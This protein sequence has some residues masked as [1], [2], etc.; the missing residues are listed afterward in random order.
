MSSDDE[1]FMRLALNLGR[2]GLGNTW[3]NPAVGAV[4]VNRLKDSRFPNTLREVIYQPGQ[5]AVHAMAARG[6][7]SPESVRAAEAALRGE[8]PT[9]GALFFYNPTTA[10][11]K[12]I[13][14][15]VVI[16]EIGSHHFAY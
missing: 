13:R 4:V 9:G 11:S 15:R 7:P 16:Q 14:S 5:F 3:P 2:R 12:W 1:H 10:R 6:T 8:D